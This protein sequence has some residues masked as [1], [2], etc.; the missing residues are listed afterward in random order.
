MKVKMILDEE[1]KPFVSWNKKC[2]ENYSN[3]KEED[4]ENDLNIE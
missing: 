1:I 2:L 3:L 4:R